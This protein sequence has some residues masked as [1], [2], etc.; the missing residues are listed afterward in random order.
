[1][2][3]YFENRQWNDKNQKQKWK[4]NKKIKF[5]I[6]ETYFTGAEIPYYTFTFAMKGRKN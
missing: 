4:I 6:A 5:S 2:N 3:I 1:M